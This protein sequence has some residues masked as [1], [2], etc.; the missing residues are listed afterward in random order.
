MNA[1]SEMVG[2]N[3]LALPSWCRNEL[4]TGSPF[5]RRAQPNQHSPQILPWQPLRINNTGSAGQVREVLPFGETSFALVVLAA[6]PSIG[7]RISTAAN[8][9]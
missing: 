8:A 1:V 3:A 6:H 5:G 7:W 2:R 9:A 4:D